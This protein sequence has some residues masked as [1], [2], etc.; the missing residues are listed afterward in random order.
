VGG[1][2]EEELVVVCGC[3]GGGV[4]LSLELS[5]P[6][7]S[8]LLFPPVAAARFVSISSLMVMGVRGIIV[9]SCQAPCVQSG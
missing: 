1:E 5:S 4:D 2:K 6:T 9:V 3:C 7:P 8:P